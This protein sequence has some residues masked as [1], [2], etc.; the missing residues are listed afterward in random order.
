MIEAVHCLPQSR[1]AEQEKSK[2]E[3]EK[4][5]RQAKSFLRKAM[6]CNVEISAVMNGP[7]AERAKASHLCIVFAGQER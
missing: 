2:T 4:S 1:L 6:T 3:Q 5:K 7:E